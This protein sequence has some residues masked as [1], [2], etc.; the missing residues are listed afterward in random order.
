MQPISLAGWRASLWCRGRAT[1]LGGLLSVLI[2]SMNITTKAILYFDGASKGNGA[3]FSAAG[4]GA[5]IEDSS[6]KCLAQVATMEDCRQTGME[7][8]VRVSF[9]LSR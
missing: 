6:G 5:Y 4:A 3:K 1:N 9:C 8:G 2:N 7:V